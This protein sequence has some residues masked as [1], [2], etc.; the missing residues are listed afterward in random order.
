MLTV[1]NGKQE[2]DNTWSATWPEF[3]ANHRIGDLVHRS[4]DRE[5]MALESQLRKK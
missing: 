5:L 2:Q 1:Q 3:W 4:G